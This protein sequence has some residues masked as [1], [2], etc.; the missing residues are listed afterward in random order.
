MGTYNW[1]SRKTLRYVC[2]R[3]LDDLLS[4]CAPIMKS[5]KSGP[6]RT[7]PAGPAPT[8]MVHGTP[9]LMNINEPPHVSTSS[10]GTVNYECMIIIVD[11]YE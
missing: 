11:E 7:G 2:E 10:G 1:N 5:P 6:A 4:F 8:P 3:R 9:N